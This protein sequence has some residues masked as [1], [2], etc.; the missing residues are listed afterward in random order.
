MF[1]YRSLLSN[2]VKV[3][4]LPFAYST[5][6]FSDDMFRDLQR[7]YPSDELI[8]SYDRNFP[9]T[10][11]RE[12][13]R[14]QIPVRELIS[15]TAI[16]DLWLEFFSKIRGAV[17]RDLA[18][19]LFADEVLSYYGRAFFDFLCQSEVGLRGVDDTPLLFDFQIGVN[20]PCT[21]ESSVRGTH[22]DNPLEV[23]A[24]LLYFPERACDDAGLAIERRVGAIEKYGKFEFSGEFETVQELPYAPNH[25]AI[26]L[27]TFQSFHSVRPRAPSPISRKL[28]NVIIEI[29][30]RY[31]GPLFNLSDVLQEGSVTRALR[32]ICKSI[33]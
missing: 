14:Y 5:N 31:R 8:Y 22:L 17:F 11:L 23:F 9:V 29:N 4:S 10:G 3:P 15:I 16:D 30:P 28:L 1:E 2:F 7:N 25:G 33:F 32:R 24:L 21:I 18:T 6:V 27:N 19:Q 12:N 20:S 13:S 26:F